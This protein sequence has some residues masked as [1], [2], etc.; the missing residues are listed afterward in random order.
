MI[1]KASAICDVAIWIISHMTSPYVPIRD[2]ES[3]PVSIL[4][5][6]NFTFLVIGET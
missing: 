5:W 3:H 1:V 2:A 4:P 6:M